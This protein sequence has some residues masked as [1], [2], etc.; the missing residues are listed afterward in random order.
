MLSRSARRRGSMLLYYLMLIVA[1]VVLLFPIVWMVSCAFKSYKAIY[2]LPPEW[3]PKDPTFDNFRRIFFGD[4]QRDP[5]FHEFFR[6]S[7]ILSTSTALLS[8][9][10]GALAAYGFVRYPFRG[11]KALLLMILGAQMFPGIVLLIP[12]YNQFSK[13]GL[14]DTYSGQILIYTVFNL[15]FPIWLLRGFYVTVPREL[16]DASFIDGCN[17]LD[18]LLK[19]VL[20]IVKPGLV[21]VAVFTFL[22]SWDVFLA[23]LL[24]TSRIEMKNLPVGMTLQ[25]VGEHIQQWGVLMAGCTVITI[26]VILIFILFQRYIVQGIASGAVKG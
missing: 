20:P 26:P 24:L 12:I 9:A 19:V 10:L 16:E 21:A 23:N 8:T 13:W 1:I 5:H 22:S 4:S 7:M 18:A 6:N 15:P 3:I 14:L 11:S 2:A 17:R 25:Y